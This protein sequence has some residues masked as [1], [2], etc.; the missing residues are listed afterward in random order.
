MFPRLALHIR[1][2]ALNSSSQQG[3]T[4]VE[5]VAVIMLLAISLA[6]VTQVISFA[7]SRNANVIL[8]TRAVALAQSYLDE[9]GGKRFDEHSATRG[10]PPCRNNTCTEDADF[11]LDASEQREDY[12]DVDDYHGLIEGYELPG[13]AGPVNALQDSEGNV[14]AGYEN[15][16]VEISV[17][18]LLP[19]GNEAALF[20][21]P[22]EIC[23]PDIDDPVAVDLSESTL[24][25][26]SQSAKLITVKVIH[27]DVQQGWDFSL[28]KSNF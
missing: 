23:A 14:R 17:R 19:C 3:L 28:F 5:L 27:R 13:D 11:G 25:T 21:F 24:L 10:I 4:L 15:F 8:E 7:I 16:R 22:P 2:L 26:A 18:Y 1:G 12:D 9:I 20:S 6:G